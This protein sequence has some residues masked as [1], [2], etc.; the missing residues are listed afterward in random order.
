MEASKSGNDWLA[1]IY[2]KKASRLAK[3]DVFKSG[4]S[5]MEAPDSG[6]APTE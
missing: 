4:R 5:Q 2:G 3:R 6:D 1:A